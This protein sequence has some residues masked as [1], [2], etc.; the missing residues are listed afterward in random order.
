MASDVELA[1]EIHVLN[2]RPDLRF[3]P[4][5]IEKVPDEE[6][7]YTVEATDPD[8]VERVQI[9]LGVYA[10]I[11]GAE[12]TM[13]HDDGVNGG[14]E[15][16][17]DGVYSVV[18]SVREGTPLGTHEV[19]LR[20]YDTYG[21]L[22]TGSSV[23]TLVEPEAPGVSEGGLSTLVLGGL[24]LAVFLGALVVLSLMVRRGGD[25]DGV[26]RFGMQ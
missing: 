16:A 15:L 19:S 2:D 12:W 8:G 26:D 24:G 23:I 3:E 14:D 9:R 25:G 20:A 6:A 18:L 5:S 13:M 11:G 17:G 21:E 10:P 1:V 7:V 4:T 22:N